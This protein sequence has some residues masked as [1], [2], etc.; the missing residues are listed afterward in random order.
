MIFDDFDDAVFSNG[1]LLITI[2]NELSIPLG[3]IDITL[4]HNPSQS[5]IGGSGVVVLGP[6]LKGESKSGI[7]DISPSSEVNDNPHLSI[8]L[9]G[10]Y[11]TKAT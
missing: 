2:Q 7:P 10:L 6:I 11:F 5:P 8:D 4:L 1:Q 9:R 3:D